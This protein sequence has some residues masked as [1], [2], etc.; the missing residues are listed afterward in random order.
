LLINKI[1]RI[2]IKTVSAQKVFLIFK[3]YMLNSPDKV[4]NEIKRWYFKRLAEK[5][6]DMTITGISQIN[7]IVFFLISMVFSDNLESPVTSPN[8]SN[9]KIMVLRITNVGSW[10]G[11]K[12]N[13]IMKKC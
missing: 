8:D 4:I 10:R 3:R 7:K 13:D 9:S 1:E 6:I 5:K 12:S 2:Q 11:V